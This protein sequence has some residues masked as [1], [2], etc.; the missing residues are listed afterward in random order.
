VEQAM[1][2]NV[3]KALGSHEKALMIQARRASALSSNIVNADTPGYKARDIDFKQALR[4]SQG[5]MLK[6]Q[7]TSASHMSSFGVDSMGM[8]LKY[9]TPGQPSLDGN[10]VDLD[11]EKSA[12][13][14]NAVRYQATLH[15]LTRKFN[16]MIKAFKEE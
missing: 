1:P 12:Y 3:D 2:F 16:G 6:L 5:D 14:E 15:F 8:Q 4:N 10:T 9:R 11:L 7:N 13:S